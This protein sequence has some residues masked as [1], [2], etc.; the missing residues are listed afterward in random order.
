[1][2]ITVLCFCPVYP[3]YRLEKTKPFLGTVTFYQPT[4][5]GCVYS[6]KVK[7][8]RV[9]LSSYCRE[10]QLIPKAEPEPTNSSTVE[11][12]TKV[13]VS[14]TCLSQLVT[15]STDLTSGMQSASAAETAAD[16]QFDCRRSCQRSPFLWALVCQADGSAS[17]QMS[18]DSGPHGGG[19]KSPVVPGSESCSLSWRLLSA[20]HS[21]FVAQTADNMGPVL[22]HSG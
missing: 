9:R 2:Y 20:Q 22:W 17:I 3:M 4:S 11:A 19:P 6:R 21:S 16:Q 10:L 18:S 13:T 8:S 14:V 5:F 1:M 15:F 12:G 7:G